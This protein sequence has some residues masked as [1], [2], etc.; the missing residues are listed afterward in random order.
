MGLLK[1]ILLYL[2]VILIYIALIKTSPETQ[3]NLTQED[4]LFENAGAIAFFLAFII[5]TYL[6]IQSKHLENLFFGIKTKRNI[7]YILLAILFLISCG[8]EISWGQ[9]IFGWSTPESLMEMNAQQETNFHNLWLFQSYNS[10]GSS[11]SFMELFLNAGRLYTIFWMLYCVL[12]PIACSISVQIKKL[13]N[14]IGIPIVPLWIG[15]FFLVNYFSLY[16]TLYIFHSHMDEANRIN[17]VRE[18]F[19]AI[20]FLIF[21]FYSLSKY[22]KAMQNR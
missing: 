21:A 8:E 12:I 7:F 5:F 19:Q 18:S 6:F 20:G 9:R 11:K 1:K 3:F 22:R 13:V 10:D 17:E 14:Y 15:G 16:A 2:S 4:G